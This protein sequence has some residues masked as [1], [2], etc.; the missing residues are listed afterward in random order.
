MVTFPRVSTAGGSYLCRMNIHEY[1][2]NNNNN[3]NTNICNVRSVS[4]HTESEAQKELE[5]FIGTHKYLYLYI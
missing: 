4:K 3:N 1:H 5:C 2:N